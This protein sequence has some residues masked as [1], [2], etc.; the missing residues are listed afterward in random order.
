MTKKY[1]FM[2]A[3]LLAG[4]CLA[5][6]LIDVQSDFYTPMSTMVF[7]DRTYLLTSN[8]HAL[9][10]MGNGLES[11]E[12]ILFL[13]FDSASLPDTPV[14]RAWLRMASG[15]EGSMGMT[16]TSP[17]T[18]SVHNVDMDVT[19]ILNYSVTPRDFYVNENHI[20]DSYASLMVFKDGVCYWDITT[21]VNQWI[22]FETTNGEQGVENLG[23]AVTGREDVNADNP[24]INMHPG[25]WSS[26]ADDSAN[27]M[28]HTTSPVLIFTECKS[29][30]DNAWI[31]DW[32]ND[33]GYTHQHWLMS[34]G[35]GRFLPS[36]EPDGNV[37][38]AYGDPN[39]MWEEETL[40]GDMVIT[41]PFLT[42]HP[43]V[44]SV[45]AGDQPNWVDGVYGGIYRGNPY[46]SHTLT[47]NIPTGNQTG[48]LK[49]MVQYDWYDRGTVTV[50]IDGATDVTPSNFVDQLIGNGQEDY[51]WYRSTKVFSLAHNP[52]YIAVEFI[53]SGD[54][55][56]I[57]AF[58][59]TT[60]L[61]AVLPAGPLRDS[62][63]IDMD[64]S[65]DLADWAVMTKN[66]NM[67]GDGLDGDCDGNGLIDI[68][69]I[70]ELAENWLDVSNY[71][72]IPV[73]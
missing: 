12:T 44:D 21:L 41:N 35:S 66:W 58:S 5:S 54:E 17:V 32:S 37:D 55:P 38:N 11:Y 40:I 30:F 51:N 27:P 60:A 25:F 47:A 69:D 71:I 24:E 42:W 23:L 72:F 28:P 26:R 43:Y 10:D 53:V 52:E 7:S 2:T 67:E 1:F 46:A 56:Y 9:I 31:P 6:T 50:D 39:M 34:A 14:E 4:N 33:P 36:H 64:G 22:L 29:G 16:T 59:V 19:N 8:A 68:L 61:D 65:V 45:V 3:I 62:A 20:L 73:N 48:S 13:K 18:V 63:D 57:D 70:L 15:A 49:V